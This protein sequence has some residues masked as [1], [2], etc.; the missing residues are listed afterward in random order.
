M[1]A[2]ISAVI[3][4]L[5]SGLLVKERK[6]NYGG[7][8]CTGEGWVRALLYPILMLHS[9]FQSGDSTRPTAHSVDSSKHAYI[10]NVEI[11]EAI[12]VTV[13]GGL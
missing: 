6:E 13:R 9:P 5:A 10:Q 8:S 4:D 7:C 12:L 2:Y 3:L 11:G 1:Y